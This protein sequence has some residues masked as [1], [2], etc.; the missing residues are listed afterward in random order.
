MLGVVFNMTNKNINK[1]WYLNLGNLVFWR[2]V[3]IMVNKGSKGGEV[4]FTGI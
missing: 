4:F 1:R 2:E 3:G